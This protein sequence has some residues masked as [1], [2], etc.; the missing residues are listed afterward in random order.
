MVVDLIMRAVG[1]IGWMKTEEVLPYYCESLIHLN[2]LFDSGM[3]FVNE[4]GLVELNLNEGTYESLK[5]EFLH[6][7][8]KLVDAYLKK[9]EASIFLSKYAIRENGIFLPKDEKIRTFVENY[10]VLYEKFGNAV[11]TEDE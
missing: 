11:D 8:K 1:L 6:H 9:E 10:Y 7:Y 5:S 4:A 3:I 2:L